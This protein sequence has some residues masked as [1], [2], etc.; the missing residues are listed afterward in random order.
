MSCRNLLIYLGPEIQNRVIPIF[1]YSLKPGGFLF[2]GTSEGIS[3]HGDLFA[4]LDKKQ[5][6]FQAREHASATPRLP[7]L[8][9]DARSETF[10]SSAMKGAR[11][12][13]YPL[14]Q[15]V[16]AQVLERF[17][18]P[19]VV[20]N[21]EGDIVYYSTRTGKYLEPPQGAPSRQ[22]LTMARKGLR[23]ELRN[24]LREA[25]VSRRTVVRDDIAV[26]DDDERLHLVKLTI[27]SIAEQ[28]AGE[29]LY[30]ILFEAAGSPKARVEAGQERVPDDTADLERE[31]RDTKE[32]LQATIEEYETALE[33]LKPS[34][35]E[36]VSVN[37][38]AQSSNEELEASKE[39]M[40]SLN[41]ELNTI[42]AELNEKIEELDRANSDLRNLFESTQIATVFL[43]GNLV[44]RTFT[45]AASTFFNL[46][47]SDIGRPLTDLSNQLD[48]PELERDIENVFRS[49]EGLEHHLARDHMDKHYL[50]R[51]IPYRDESNKTRGVVVTMVDVTSLARAEEHQK[52]LISEL[53]H[54]VKNMLAVVISIANQ[55]VESASSKEAYHEALSGRLLA[56]ARA[57]GLLSRENWTEAS[58][59]ELIR[60]E[61][62]PFDSKQLLVEGPDVRLKPLQALSLGMVVHELAT[63]A[64][65]YG[66]LSRKGGR[67]AVTWVPTGDRLELEWRERGG[68]PVKSPQENGFG[69]SL[70]KGE[71]EYRLDGKVETTFDP[72]GLEV[73]ISIPLE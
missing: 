9:G 53:N 56:M 48:Y 33:E 60:Q 16:K 12:S 5:R 68:P 17:S 52:V 35:E 63:N 72:K 20:V 30:L 28:H 67:I 51:V 8:M 10:A 22:L 24:A 62:E 39:E 59:N 47:P 45:P 23:L 50:V 42:N 36:L 43:D 31:L 25:T 32:R 27:E 70:L 46:R 40:Q 55:T 37:E 41:E 18:P 15:A 58:V 38:E 11:K 34:N 69:L 21:S 4:T 26:E 29:P 61:L 19:H 7:I 3:Q 44:I 1:H 14:R 66:G 64:A 6:I 2:L 65:K 71:I 49:G 13:A 73:R 54:R 57:Y